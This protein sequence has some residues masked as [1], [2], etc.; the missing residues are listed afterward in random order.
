MTHDDEHLTVANAD[1]PLSPETVDALA[2]VADG[3]A[4]AFDD[5]Y[6]AIITADTVD[7]DYQDIEL[8]IFGEV[9]SSSENLSPYCGDADISLA[10]AAPELAT[11][12]RTLYH[13]VGRLNAEN[14]RLRRE[15]AQIALENMRTF[16]A[17]TW[18]DTP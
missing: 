17:P 16:P 7:N 14:A 1:L 13:A 12:A 10:S 5:E 2:V 11:T 18:P 9:N 3:R 4:W 8:V 6:R 15:L